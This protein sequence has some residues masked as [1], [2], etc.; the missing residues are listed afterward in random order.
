MENIELTRRRFLQAIGFGALSLSFPAP[1][2]AEARLRQLGPDTP[3][4]RI[5]V[6]KLLVHSEPNLAS[7]SRGFY[8]YDDIIRIPN[9]FYTENSQ[10]KKVPWYQ[11]G[12]NAYI[13]AAWVQ[14]VFNKPNAV[15]DQIPEGGCLGEITVG[16]TTV[17]YADGT[18]N[19]MRTF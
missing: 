7:S 6:H 15:A 9:I 5:L 4:G 19:F 1:K 10:G 2:P 8:V 3:L 14:P 11:M 16:K 18:K 13:H 17:Y 12:E